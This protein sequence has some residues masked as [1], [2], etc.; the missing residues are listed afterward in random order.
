MADTLVVIADLLKKALNIDASKIYI[1][2]QKWKVPTDNGAYFSVSMVSKELYGGNSSS[3]W[4][5]TLGKYFQVQSQHAQE[6]VQVDI[7]SRDASARNMECLIPG[8]LTGYLADES[9]Q[10]NAMKWSSIVSSLDLSEEVGTS[11][12]TRYAYRIKVLRMYKQVSEIPYYDKF[13][14]PSD[15]TA[16]PGTILPPDV[17]SEK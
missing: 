9:M 10:K 6:I 1:Y 13:N 2:N 16:D 15:V 11:M 17:S 12:L 4:D 14:V 8:I 5:V 7:F 3:Y